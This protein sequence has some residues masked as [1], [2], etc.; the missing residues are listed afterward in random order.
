MTDPINQMDPQSPQTAEPSQSRVEPSQTAPQVPPAMVAPTAP[1]N[2]PQSVNEPPTAP[3]DWGNLTSGDAVLDG[4]IKAFTDA[5]GM[6]PQDFMQI[7]GNAVDY[8]DPELI[9]KTLLNTKYA[10]KEG[11]IKEL[12]NALIHQSV[13]A[14]NA[15]RNTAYSVAGSKEAWDQ[16]V[17]IFN[18]NAPAYLKETV[19]TMI[20]NGKVQEGAQ[21]LMN[22]VGSYG[23]GASSMP[24]MGGGMTPQKG[25]SFDELKVEL[26]KLVQEAGG[27]SLESGTYGRRYQDLMRRRA[28]GRQQGI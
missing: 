27:A 13:N 19:K 25:L 4:A 17:A 12:A 24:Q 23:A 3:N 1:Q 6:S 5:S 18:A 2:A 22:S 8:G 28:I 10:G 16:A 15:V 20:D 14:E 7:V 11:T 21:M 26:G 9:D